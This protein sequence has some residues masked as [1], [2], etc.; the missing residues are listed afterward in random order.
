MPTYYQWRLLFG[1]DIEPESV[2]ENFGSGTFEFMRDDFCTILPSPQHEVAPQLKCDLRATFDAEISKVD[3]AKLENV[4]N[5][6]ET[7]QF[8]PVGW[9]TFAFWKRETAAAQ[10]FQNSKS[11]NGKELQREENS[12]FDACAKRNAPLPH[13]RGSLRAPIFKIACLLFAFLCGAISRAD[14]DSTKA[15]VSPERLK[16]AVSE[17]EKLT[18][19]TLKDSGVPGIAITIV[20][21]DDVL[22]H[23]GF[24]VR[25]IGKPEKI[26]ADTVFQIASVS[27]PVSA[28]IMAALVGEGRVGWDDRVIDHDD[29]FRVR[30]P[31]V[32]EEC[33]LRDLL[34]HRSGLPDHCGDLLEDIGY[35]AP[36]ILARLRYVPLDGFRNHYNYTNVGYSEACYASAKACGEEWSEVAASKLFKPLGM[37][38]TS[39]RFADFENAK[40]RALL[41]TK[42]DGKWVAKYVRQPD[43]QAPAGGVSSTIDD[44]SR[45]LRL[46]VANGKFDGK[47]V[48]S[49]EALAETHKPQIITAFNQA[50]CRVTSYG[51]GWIV[52]VERGGRVVWKHSGEFALGVRSEVAVIPESNLAIVILCNAAPNGI[53]E[54][55]TESFFDYVLDGKQ[56]R[57]WV[58]FANRM[59][60]ETERHDREKE[61]DYSKPLA[62][63]SPPLKLSAYTG[64]YAN[65]FFGTIEVAEKQGALVLRIGKKP[66]EFPLKHWDRDDFIYQPIGEMA[67]G[68]SGV[69][70]SISPAGKA[71]R[72]LIENLNPYGQGTFTEVK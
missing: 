41:H 10:M 47:Q 35:D 63:P 51:L 39:T 12:N 27:K 1:L 23:Q 6:R 24:G 59:V 16:L 8:S 49:A 33:R 46:L 72:V 21:K 61:R 54:A 71:D 55:L 2:S 32:T 56:N 48:I 22:M 4:R 31:Y 65:D 68:L 34:C 30:V 14:D 26:D 7:R 38:N 13:G 66:L 20:H 62:K 45:W 11:A 15:A 25:A 17:L 50:D 18:N 29:R 70:F 53:P 57:D 69:C 44:L 43:A 5:P 36:T 19:K 67:G 37:T 3:G 60:A 9:P 64:K 58:E 42:V 28:T 52:V 40:N